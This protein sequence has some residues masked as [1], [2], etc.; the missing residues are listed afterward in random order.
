MK[1]Y[2]SIST[3]LAL[4]KSFKSNVFFNNLNMRFSKII[5]SAEEAVKEVK[6]GDE[7]LIGGFGL[8]GIPENLLRALSKRKDEVKDLHII[9]NN[10]GVQDAGNGLLISNGMVKRITGSYVGENKILE[11]LYLS[12][13]MELNLLPQGTLA[14][15][16]RCGGAGI[17]AFYTPTGFGTMIQEGGF[18]IKYTSDGKSEI[19]S[20]PKP[21]AFYNG[22]NYVLEE[23][24]RAKWAFVK[25]LKADKE[26]NLIFR[27]TARNFNQ[28]IAT[29]GFNTI[30]EVE[31][32]VEAGEIK[33]D[34]VHCPGIFVK[35]IFIG[36]KF[37]KRIERTRKKPEGNQTNE[38]DPKHKIARRAAEEL[39][40]GMYV[41][42][43]IGIPNLITD[44]IPN[45]KHIVFHSENGMLGM[46]PYPFGNEDSDLISA[47]K[48]PASE[49]KGCSYFPSSESFGMVRGRHV[50]LTVLGALQV[51]N[52]GDIANWIV[53]GK[54]IKGMGGAMDLV[55]SGGRVIVTMEH[56]AKGNQIKIMEKCSF[57]LTGKGVIEKVITEKAV[58]KYQPGEGLVLTDLFKG[59]D[60]EEVKK[61]T[62]CKFKTVEKIRVLDY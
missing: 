57:P 61:L 4:K 52:S 22:R 21:T 11:E 27:K 44:Y 12:G 47:I 62:G 2:K 59:V 9:S 33:P 48:E 58:F 24:I 49:L 14:E 36:E 23:S 35:N 56:C 53:P 13:K 31:E 37:E 32:I 51:S 7:I 45:N 8:C 41:N 15:K 39:E 5:K 38:N 29:A 20:E 3:N 18:T 60:I 28:D 42:L 17:P 19:L 10:G 34:E 30:A 46:G 16:I 55:G 43:G 26:G 40:N 50:D 25:A 54:L 6:S 1:F